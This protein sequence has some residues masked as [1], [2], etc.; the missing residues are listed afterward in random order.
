MA[1]PAPNLQLRSDMAH[2]TDDLAGIPA[3]HWSR[4]F[5]EHVFCAFSDAQF[6]DIYEEGGRYPISPRLVACISI[7]QYMFRVSDRQ[8]VDSSIMRRDWRIALG[9]TPDYE[10]FDAS[11][12]CTFR[13]R[14]KANDK[15]RE[16]FDAVL[17][18][19]KKQGLLKRHRTV[20]VDATELLA[21][22]AVLNRCDKLKEAMRIVLN[23]LPYMRPK[24]RDRAEFKRFDGQ[25]GKEIWLGRDKGSDAKLT[26]LALDALVVLRLCGPYPVKGKDTLQRILDEDFRFDERGQPE[27]KPPDELPA[28][29]VA[30]PHEPDAG[31]GKKDRKIWTGD[32]T[33]IVET[34]HPTEQNFIVDVHTTGPRVED[35]THLPTILQRL[36]GIFP[37]ANQVL[38][39]SGYASADNSILAKTLGYDLVTPPRGN[40]TKGVIPA[41]EFNFDFQRK[42]ARCPEGHES[43]SWFVSASK[44]LR[45]KF[46]RAVCSICPRLNECTTSKEKRRTLTLSAEYEQLLADRRRAQTEE[47]EGLYAQRAGVEATISHL[48]RDHGLRRS[49]Y[50]TK[51]GRELHAI[52]SATALNV[53]RLLQCLASKDAPQKAGFCVFP[54]RFGHITRARWAHLTAILTAILDPERNREFAAAA[55]S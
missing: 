1:K 16:L 24:I 23:N 29:H 37:H 49:R 41:N 28:D 44:K 12:L 2:R 46:P 13:K 15:A 7:L 11:V 34:T 6:E 39:D 54:R 5:F 9:I 30:S 3:D 26:Q 40:T 27:P 21:D 31:I 32:K 4:L 47:F 52:L 48:V 10:G 8:A 33:H 36:G 55:A 18:G 17:Y 53:R 50:R 42:I 20:R 22:V 38:A 45:I 19:I 51:A 25:Y 43:C 35:S 14:V